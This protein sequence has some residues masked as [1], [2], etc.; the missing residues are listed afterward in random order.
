MPIVHED[1]EDHEGWTETK[2][3][4]VVACKSYGSII[5]NIGEREGITDHKIAVRW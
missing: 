2:Y 5:G 3:E 4:K 1:H